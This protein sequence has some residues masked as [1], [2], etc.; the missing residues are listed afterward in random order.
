[1][2]FNDMISTGFGGIARGETSFRLSS[3]ILDNTKRSESR[4]VREAS[5]FLINP[6]RG[7]NRIVTGDAT[8]VKGN[9]SDPYDWRPS[10][11]LNLRGG[12]RMIGEGESISENTNTY[13]FVEASI[14]YGDPRELEQRRPFDRFDAIGQFD[15]GDKSHIGRLLIRGD[16]ISKPVWGNSSLALQQ[17][18]DYINNEAYEYGGQNFG[19]GLI[20]FFDVSEN[21][22]LVTRAQAYWTVLGAVNSNLS[23]LADVANQERIREYDYGPGVG[24]AAELHLLRKNRPFVTA[25]YRYTFIDVSNGSVY[26]NDIKDIGL[27]ATHDVH[28]S[29]LRF[30]IPVSSRMSA[31]VDGLIFYRKSKYDVSGSGLPPSVP[32]GPRTVSQRNPE[33]RA[34]IGYRWW[35]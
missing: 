28:Q 34:F 4:F 25:R 15:F 2:S 24:G 9:P 33:L 31:G 32:Q 19:A 11:Q 1:M 30:D 10:Y 35:K 27:N 14:A 21:L 5:A 7:F 16:I 6:I 13:G 29:Q 22:D 12:A 17:D 20:S 23:F 26:N 18:F 8:E 3:M